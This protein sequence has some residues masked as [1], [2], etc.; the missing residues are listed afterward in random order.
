MFVNCCAYSHL[1][2]FLL[3]LHYAMNFEQKI[4]KFVFGEFIDEFIFEPK[5]KQL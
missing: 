3:E 2:E 1:Y 5:S 4:T